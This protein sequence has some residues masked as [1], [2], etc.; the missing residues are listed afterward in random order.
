MDDHRTLDE[1]GDAS[2]E[3][4]P[5]SDE[6]PR[7]SADATPESTETD[8]EPVEPE[9]DATESRA[10]GE[11]RVDGEETADDEERVD[12]EDEAADVADDEAEPPATTYR[13]TPDGAACE[14][15]GATV[16]RRWRDG[17]AFVCADCKEW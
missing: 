7:E 5:E 13:W 8:S 1:F 11:E 3:R 6:A 4:D 2:A 17:G 9:P 14:G 12:D 15:C 10:D 16:E